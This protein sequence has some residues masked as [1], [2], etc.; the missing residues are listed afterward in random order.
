[1]AEFPDFE[2]VV[3]A[4]KKESLRRPHPLAGIALLFLA[5]CQ[6]LFP[7]TA[8]SKAEARFSA[9]NWTERDEDNSAQGGAADSRN[10]RRMQL[11]SDSEGGLSLEQDSAAFPAAAAAALMSGKAAP[12]LLAGAGSLDFSAFPPDLIGLFE[13]L[14]LAFKACEFSGIKAASNSAFIPVLLEYMTRRLPQPEDVWFADCAIAADGRSSR[15]IFRL[16]FPAESGIA[17]PVFASAEAIL[18][19]GEWRAAD[20]IFDGDSYEKAIEQA[21]I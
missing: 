12:P 13:S 8:R 10:I 7:Q 19:E 15:A 6:M 18:E 21:G 20:V 3:I 17:G 5:L 11:A 16:G 4:A 1:M 9:L 2:S 14:A